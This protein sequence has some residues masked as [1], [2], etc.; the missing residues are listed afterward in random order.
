M[1]NMKVWTNLKLFALMETHF[2]PS[3]ETISS[4]RISKLLRKVNLAGRSCRKKSFSSVRVSTII[5]ALSEKT[6]I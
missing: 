4:I 3:K 1:D 2:Q 6:Q 5:K